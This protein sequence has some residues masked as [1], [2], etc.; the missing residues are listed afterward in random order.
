MENNICGKMY[1]AVSAMCSFWEE[2]K[3]ESLRNLIGEVKR[4][5][6]AFAKQLSTNDVLNDADEASLRKLRDWIENFE[7]VSKSQM[8]KNSDYF[9]SADS[10]ACLALLNEVKTTIDSYFEPPTF[11]PQQI[12]QTYNLLLEN[13]KVIAEVMGVSEDVFANKL[14][15][16]LEQGG[17]K[18]DYTDSAKEFFHNNTDLLDELI[19]VSDNEVSMK[20]K[21]WNGKRDKFGKR[22]ME[23]LE[24][25]GNKKKCATILEENGLIKTKANYFRTKIEA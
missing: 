6:P 23:P 16:W 2:K 4:L 18:R 11:E 15:R 21:E 14:K 25:F 13:K 12:E 19:E 3:T 10:K 17:T 5:F 20:L 24:E 22:L 7:M 9:N 1:D 8:E